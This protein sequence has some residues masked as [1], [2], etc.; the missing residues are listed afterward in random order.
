MNQSFEIT[1]QEN[2]AIIHLSDSIL[3]DS[4]ITEMLLLV[5]EHIIAGNSNWI[6]DGSKLAYCNSIGLN[7]FIRVLTKARNKG[8]ECCLAA[9]QPTVQKLMNLSKLNEIFTSFASVTAAVANFNK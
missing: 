5:D 4:G 1:L 3:S 2:C 8:G 9:I 7:L 6:L